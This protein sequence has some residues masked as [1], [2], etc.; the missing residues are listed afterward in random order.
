L[1]SA[2]RFSANTAGAFSS[3]ARSAVTS[4]IRASTV[5]TCEAELCLRFCQSVRSA[6]IACTRLSASSASRASAW[7]SAR[8]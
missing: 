3:S 2:R 7:A 1:I 8:T 6:V 5:A 4:V